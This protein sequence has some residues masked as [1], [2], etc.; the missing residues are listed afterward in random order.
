MSKCCIYHIEDNAADRRLVAL[1]LRSYDVRVEIHE[2]AD[3]EHA[4]KLL[5][6]VDSG[7]ACLPSIL[8]VDINIP[9]VS[10]LEVVANVKKLPKLRNI[11]VAI[12][13]SSDDPDDQKRCQ[14]LGAD[15]YLRKPMNLNDFI[16]LGKS[17]LALASTSNGDCRPD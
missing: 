12:L 10:G 8:I 13:T 14:T 1:A 3:G 4:L 9:K 2:A 17:L 15:I 6:D 11:P 7:H 16:A 5:S